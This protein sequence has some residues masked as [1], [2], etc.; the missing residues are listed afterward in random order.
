MLMLMLMLMLTAFLGRKPWAA[1][2]GNRSGI[3]SNSSSSCNTDNHF[4][5]DPAPRVG[6]PALLTGNL[7]CLALVVVPSSSSSS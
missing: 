6:P 5:A 4:G 2:R 1:D 3:S 7:P